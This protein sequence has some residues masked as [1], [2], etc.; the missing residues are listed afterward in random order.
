[1]LATTT[2]PITGEEVPDISNP[3]IADL[4]AA[5]NDIARAQQTI[6][7]G[8]TYLEI[9]NSGVIPDTA[10]GEKIATLYEAQ[11]ALENAQADLDTTKLTAPISGTVTSLDLNV[12]EHA[13]TGS[14]VTLS[15]LSQPYTL[16]AYI[17]EEDWSN[18]RVG[19]K[20]N[21]T[22]D[23]LP[24]QSFTGTVTLVYPELSASFETSVVHL[25]VTLD[26]SIS[27]D[28]PAG[29]GVTVEVIGGEAKN[30]LLV[31]AAAVHKED[32]GKSYV[33]VVQNG[34]QA[35]REVTIGLKNDTYAEVK[36]GLEAGEV[37]VSK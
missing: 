9:L 10:V 16:D 35:E 4:T 19:N 7:K 2:D 30:A 32:D 22:F 23:L 3:S 12:G 18:A 31:P 6:S 25:V 29:T 27:Q 15:Q 20:V 33:T 37:V 13:E 11:L 24:E 26:K 1:V 34:Q 17:N 21:V 14:V 5:R 28:L 36:T 8:Q